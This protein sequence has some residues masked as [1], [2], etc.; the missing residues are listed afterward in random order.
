MSC[1][2]SVALAYELF[3]SGHPR[4]VAPLVDGHA[5]SGLPPGFARRPS[6]RRSCRTGHGL[7]LLVLGRA[8]RRAAPSSGW[9][10]W[11]PAPT[12]FALAL[13]RARLEHDLRPAARRRRTRRSRW[14]RSR[15]ATTDADRARAVLPGC[16]RARSARTAWRSGATIASPGA[17]S[18]AA[19][20]D[21]SHRRRPPSTPT[22][23]ADARLVKALRGTVGRGDA[24]GRRGRRSRAMANAVVP[25][26]GQRRALG[27]AG[28][29]GPRIAPG[30]EARLAD[31]LTRLGHSRRPTPREPAAARGGACA[32]AANSSTR[33]TRCTISCMV[34]G[35]A[36]AGGAGERGGRASGSA[37]GPE[38]L[39]GRARDANWSGEALAT[40]FDDLPVRRRLGRDQSRSTE[41]RRPR[42][43]RDVPGDGHCRWSEPDACADGSVLV[44]RDVSEERRTASRT[45]RL[46]ERLAQSEAL[47]NLVAGIA[48][49]LNNPLQAVLGHLELVQHGR[50]G[51]AAARR[52]RCA[53]STAR[54]TARRA[55]SATCCCW[56]AGGTSVTPAR[57]A[58]ARAARARSPC[59][60]L[61]AAARASRSQ[62]DLPPGLPPTVRGDARAAAAG[63]PQHPDSTPS[64]P[65]RTRGGRIEV[66]AATA[67]RRARVIEIRDNGPGLA[68]DVLPRV[69]DPFFTTRRTRQRTGP[70]ADAP[71]RARSSAAT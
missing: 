24:R 50:P 18:V 30:D 61:R 33:S 65:W 58:H 4:Q 27:V 28:V 19:A 43:R 14:L 70:R 69:F 52:R 11:R 31:S 63:V 46:R 71:D 48:H 40:W 66:R 62:R 17:S 38:T 2:D 26:R 10:R 53:W 16:W 68:P 56:R 23:A 60:R 32:R 41:A 54:P 20:S 39:A 8:R 3:A 37:D 29:P 22:D 51:P 35:S 21:G 44:A 7:G 67:R 42:A 6:W 5:R 13:A 36:T 15:R 12:A 57:S 9:T 59:A 64:R 34:S 25:L 49:E 47:S 55:S 1:P 45:G